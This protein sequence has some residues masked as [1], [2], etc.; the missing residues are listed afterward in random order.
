[1]DF[2]KCTSCGDVLFDLGGGT[3]ECNKGEGLELL[4]P[5]TVDA[6]TEKHVPVADLRPEGVHVQVGSTPHPML[7]EHHI[8]WIF[9]QTTFGGLYCTLQ[10]GDPPEATLHL[11][12]DEVVSVYEHCNL[13]GLWKAQEPVLPLTFDT[14]DVA[15]SPEFTA[16]CMDPAGTGAGTP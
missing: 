13:H 16:G 6:A 7:P 11:Q 14:N 12:A 1:M 4:Q 5:N 2:Y 10:P 8:E 15:C 9:V 3:H